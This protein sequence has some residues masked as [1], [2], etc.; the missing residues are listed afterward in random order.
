MKYTLMPYQETASDAIMEHL[1]KAAKAHTIG[2]Q[3]VFALSAPTGAGKTVIATSVFERIL[4][5]SDD[6]V[7]DENAVILWLSDNPDL[8]EQS[9]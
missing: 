2:Q 3:A 6:R 9:R 7:E 8:N 1:D 5:P 4:I